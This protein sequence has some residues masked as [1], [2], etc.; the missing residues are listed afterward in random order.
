MQTLELNT[1]AAPLRDALRAANGE[2]LL[3]TDDGQPRYV[4]RR[5][6]DDDL[7]DEIIAQHPDFLASIQSARQQKAEGKVKALAEIRAK[8]AQPDE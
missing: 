2:P 1:L 5:L 6:V 8:Y 4:V 3:L 7:A